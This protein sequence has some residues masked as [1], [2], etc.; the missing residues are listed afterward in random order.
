MPRNLSR[1]GAGFLM[2]Q[3]GPRFGYVRIC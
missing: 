2:P 3:P 1:Y